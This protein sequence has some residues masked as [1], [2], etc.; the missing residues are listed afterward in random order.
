[1]APPV[2]LPNAYDMIVSYEN[3]ADPSIKWR[4]TYTFQSEEP[5]SIGAGIV[6]ALA[7]YSI[8]L[9]RSDS[10]ATGIALYNWARGRQPYPT[11]DA[12]ETDSLAVPGE[13]GA[14]W[15]HLASEYVP[16]GGEQVLRIDHEPGVGSKPGRSFVRGLLGTGDISAL[17]GGG[18]ELVPLVA[19]LQTDLG[20]III[21]SGLTP[22]FGGGTGG[23]N[24]CIVRYSPKTNVVHGAVSV[25]SFHVIGATTNKRSRKSSR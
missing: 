20:N 6:E 18:I 21:A 19:D 3:T 17:T 23:Q 8:C 16:V 25:T 13:A 5:P 4:Q 14:H 2:T 1:M 22:Y 7:T 12:I 11:G 10:N 15:P 9:V 24:L